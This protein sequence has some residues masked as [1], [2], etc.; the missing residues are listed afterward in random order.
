MKARLKFS[1]E[2][3]K[4]FVTLVKNLS[5][6]VTNESFGGMMFQ[7]ALRGLLLK[8]VKKMPGM[9]KT[10]VIT[11]T[12]IETLAMEW[13]LEDMV[14]VMMPF[15]RSIGYMIL[16]EMDRQWKERDRLMTVNLGMET[17]LITEGGE[18]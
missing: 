8:L 17:N 10:F 12:E 16:D 6:M 14:E 2:E 4:G 13:T 15:E 7:D 1:R 3:A 11:L 18:R 5:G 9:K